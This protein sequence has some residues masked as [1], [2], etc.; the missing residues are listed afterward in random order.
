MQIASCSITDRHGKVLAELEACSFRNKSMAETASHMKPLLE[1][2]LLLEPNSSAST[3]LFSERQKDHYSHFILRLAF[4]STEDL[5]RR[6]SRVETMLFRLRLNDENMREKN[7]FINSVNLDC[8]QVTEEERTKYRDEL[9]AVTGSKRGNDEETWVKV[10]WERVPELVE[11]R[12]V[13]VRVGQAYVPSKELS[14]MVVAEFT[15]RLDRSLEVSHPNSSLTRV[16]IMLTM[17]QVNSS[18]LASIR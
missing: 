11:S 15:K 17:C 18:C 13:F 4:S 10:D 5:R 8:E 7:E 2:Y 3:K 9:A 1:K 6:F 14:S 12:R 16:A